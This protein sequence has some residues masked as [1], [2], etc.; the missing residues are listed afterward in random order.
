[1]TFGLD[2]GRRSV[3]L[4]RVDASRKPGEAP[5]FVKGASRDFDPKL[6]EAGQRAAIVQ[7]IREC[8][9]ELGVGKSPVAIAVPRAEA[10]LKTVYLPP[11]SAE[12]RSRL[13]RFQ[14]A[15]D[16][17]FEL[18]EVVL[19]NGVV[20]EAPLPKGEVPAVAPLEVNYAA[21]RSSVL[22]GLR[23]LVREAG[24]EPGTLEISTPAAARAARLLAP[25][26][27]DA[28]L[29]LVGALASEIVL[30]RKGRLAF[31][32][33]A[34]VG[35]VGAETEP[36]WLD[37]LCAEVQ[38]SLRAAGGPT[39]AAGA[40]QP[41]WSDDAADQPKALLLA[42]GG[43]KDPNVVATLAARLGLPARVLDP[44]G[45]DS[46]PA[47]AIARGL[48]DP[49]AVA[50][51]P[52]LDMAGIADAE[53]A[54]S[55][56]QRGIVI[57]AAALLVA[58]VIFTG[59][60]WA[61]VSNEDQADRLQ[62]QLD[63]LAPDLKIVRAKLHEVTVAEDW[64][65]KKGKSLDVLLCVSKALPENDAYLTNFTWSDGKPVQLTGRIKDQAAVDTYLRRLNRDPIVDRSKLN[66]MHHKEGD[67]KE[68]GSEFMITAYLKDAPGEKTK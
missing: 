2:I 19:A 51:I 39:S 11:V 12:E 8:A 59:I 66:W 20:G 63:K 6:D 34:S 43:V 7:A 4:V 38:R 54:K 24:L 31:S 3:K 36:G 53:A 57:G 22:E 60:R 21:V 37:K 28:V 49:R 27:E 67:S 41:S 10:V 18:S 15:K 23:S 46:S 56:R 5:K 25:D 61:I 58:I 26:A 40:L 9:Q 48:A 50:G 29:V 32:R 65:K 35:S 55:I 62:K 13:I 16:V 64:E 44:L 45:G 68:R 52:I 30:L 33:S 1:M 17:P 14:A 47:F 42:G